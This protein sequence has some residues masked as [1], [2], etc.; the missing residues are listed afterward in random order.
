MKKRKNVFWN[1]S[2]NNL[3]IY[4]INFELKKPKIEF[5]SLL[6]FIRFIN[7]GLTSS[8]Q[9]YK[10]TIDN[11]Y[12]HKKVMNFEKHYKYFT[13]YENAEFVLNQLKPKKAVQ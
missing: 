9:N 4:Y 3:K 6:D 13:S 11:I 1:R 7:K 10:H 5:I 8:D 2:K 12:Y